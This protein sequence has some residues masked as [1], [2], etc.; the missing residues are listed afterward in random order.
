MMVT[1]E[2]LFALLIVYQAKHFIADF[3]LQHNYMLNKIRPG[4]DFIL[5]LSLHCSVHAG[6]TLVI[7]LLYRPSM[8]WLAGVD[9]AIHFALD[10]FRSGPR[11]LGRYNDLDK[12]LFWWILGLDQMLH[13]LT[14]L[15][16]VWMLIFWGN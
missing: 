3:L 12:P 1:I 4:W 13:H 7:C 6:F 14:H 16:I 15:W 10:R 9:F 5:P 2:T 8:W 11:Y